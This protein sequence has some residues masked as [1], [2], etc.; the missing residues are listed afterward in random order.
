[1]SAREIDTRTV[2]EALKVLLDQGID[3]GEGGLDA[4]ID[5]LVGD[6]DRD[7]PLL[8]EAISFADA[9]LLTRDHGVVLRMRDGGE[10]QVTV[11]RSR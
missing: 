3:D 6:D 5:L 9:G 8:D 10:F 7:E 2:A 11:V 1:M 4:A